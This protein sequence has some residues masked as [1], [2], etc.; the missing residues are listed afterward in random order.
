MRNSSGHIPASSVHDLS[1]H[2]HSYH[3]RKVIT[4]A[5]KEAAM[6]NSSSSKE[7]VASNAS[8]V[9]APGSDRDWNENENPVL[10][11]SRNSGAPS[12]A[13]VKEEKV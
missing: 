4:P 6:A 10:D 9:K 8:S 13:S 1:L 5:M 11:S 3:G 2:G 12:L 7:G